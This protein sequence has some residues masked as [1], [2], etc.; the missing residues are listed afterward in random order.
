MGYDKTGHFS[1]RDVDGYF[2][3]PIKIV[4]SGR[5]PGKSFG[6]KRKLIEQKGTAVWLFRD[7]Q[8]LRTSLRTW[9]DDL[10]LK[11]DVRTGIVYDVERFKLDMSE[12]AAELWFDDELKIY[13]RCLS[14]VG[15]IKHETFPLDCQ[16]LVYDEF[17]PLNNRKLGGIDSESA[18]LMDI[19]K[20]I[21]HDILNPRAKM[22]VYIF[23]NPRNFTHEFFRFF[24]ID[25]TLGYGIRRTINGVVWEFL[26]PIE[27]E[28]SHP[29]EQM[30]DSVNANL[31][32]W[33]DASHFVG[34]VPKGAVVKFTIRDGRKW[35]EMRR[36]SQHQIW[37]C[38][39][40]GH[41]DGCLSYGSADGLREDEISIERTGMRKLWLDAHQM[42]RLRYESLNV[43]SAFVETLGL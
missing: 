37:V 30:E 25:A 41:L 26:P 29:L 2:D 13:F 14:Y 16:T 1:T 38:E 35:F 39:G 5:G 18:A 40:H 28:E 8:D 43:K 23:G 4:T 3:C 7:S 10:T 42:G 24:R 33:K 31:E 12:G 15:H 17:V 34:S 27:H 6:M 32:S 36:D 19:L 9:L 22:K 20:T 11:V 21:D